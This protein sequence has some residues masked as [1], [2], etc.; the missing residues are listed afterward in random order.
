VHR[1]R[2]RHQPSTPDVGALLI[3]DMAIHRVGSERG[4]R[5]GDRRLLRKRAGEIEHGAVDDGAADA[6]DL[7]DVRS[8]DARVVPP[9]P[10]MD[11]AVPL[12]L[13]HD[14]HGSRLRA[15]QRE[16]ME[17]C[18]GRAAEEETGA[19]GV[20]MRGDHL[21]EMSPLIPERLPV[22]GHHI[23]AATHP[24][25]PSGDHEIAELTV[26]EATPQQVGTRVEDGECI[27]NADRLR[28][29]S[30]LLCAADTRRSSTH[31]SGVPLRAR[32]VQKS[33]HRAGAP[34][35]RPRPIP[36]MSIR[37]GVGAQMGRRRSAGM[38]G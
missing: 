17:H 38:R 25:N 2:P 18:G 10:R 21:D 6:V 22:L 7:D 19:A 36:W 23:A 1:R 4:V 11:T 28:H 3:L 30:S 12:V 9:D 13:G 27:G 29:S 32:I 34:P 14:V 20:E 35:P 31:G 5:G 16:A 24:A 8:D 26:P 37:G 33:S 15:I